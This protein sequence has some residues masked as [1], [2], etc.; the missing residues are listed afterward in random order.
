MP[1]YDP[2]IEDAAQHAHDAA[3]ARGE[4]GYMDPRSGLFVM[5]AG[6]LAA[7]GTCCGSGCRHCPYPAEEQAASGRPR[8]RR[9]EP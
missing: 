2:P 3:E 1:R 7:R 6:S 8:L 5:T 4:R 9:P